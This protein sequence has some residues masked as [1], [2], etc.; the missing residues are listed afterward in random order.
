MHH[1]QPDRA[2]GFTETVASLADVTVRYGALTALDR[3]GFSIRRSEIVALLGPN[4][5]G[6][7]SAISLLL[8]LQRAHNG[9]VELFGV[10]PSQLASRQRIG[11][12]LQSAALL[13]A[14]VVTILLML[15]AC[16]VAKVI[17]TPIQ[18][19]TLLL[20]DVIGVLPFCAIGL[21]I[22]ALAPA[23]GAPAI[24]NLI[25]LPM[26]FLSGL[27]IPIGLLP[28]VLQDVAP[29]WPA[30][31]L[32]QLALEVVGARNDGAA[33]LHIATLM[34]ITALCARLASRCLARA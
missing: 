11:V 32:G 33:L 20:T 24:A 15:T 2:P 19:A 28:E 27:C 21:L 29:L 4:G 16:I 25:F 9:R 26:S 34:A 3:A 6:K 12:M 23:S 10:D 22:G 13:F 8:G 18:Y 17:L 7:S 31:H 5:A 30:Y 1:S 14:L